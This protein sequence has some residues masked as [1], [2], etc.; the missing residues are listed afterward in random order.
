MA[1][2][3]DIPISRFENYL[4]G[5]PLN[6]EL[7]A[8]QKGMVSLVEEPAKAQK[9]Q[10]RRVIEDVERELTR[11]ERLD[12]KDLRA[13][14]GWPLLMRIL[15]RRFQKLHK[16]AINNSQNDPLGRSAEIAQTWAYVG[17]YER[18]KKDMESQVEEELKALRNEEQ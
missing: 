5:V 7:A 6:P 13:S 1:N 9:P 4:N 15:E 12:L 18:A 8:V 16:A 2:T 3:P 10:Q 11:A 17:L 14:E